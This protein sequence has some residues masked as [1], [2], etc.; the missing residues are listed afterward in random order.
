MPTNRI[1]ITRWTLAAL[2]S[3][4]AVGMSADQ[5]R[6]A[7][8]LQEEPRVVAQIDIPETLM[9]SDQGTG[10]DSFDAPVF[11]SGG[12]IQITTVGEPIVL[13]IGVRS[14]RHLLEYTDTATSITVTPVEGGM[15]LRVPIRDSDGN[16]TIR[17]IAVVPRFDGT[18]DSVSGIAQSIEIDLPTASIDLSSL[19]PRVGTASVKVLGTLSSFPGASRMTMTLGKGPGDEAAVAIESAAVRLGFA[20]EDIGF[21]VQFD[22]VGL[23][24]SIDT[25]TL[26]LQVG[27]AWVTSTGPDSVRVFRVAD[28]GSTGVVEAVMSDPVADPVLFT[29]TSPDGLSTFAIAAVRH[30]VA[31]PT[32]T[33]APTP[34][35]PPMPTPSPTPTLVPT[36]TAAAVPSPTA[37][38]TATPAVVP[39]LPTPTP[40]GGGG[41]NASAPGTAGGAGLAPLGDLLPMGLLIGGLYGWRRR[42][43]RPL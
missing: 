15:R 40:T 10:L 7:P 26:L 6:A 21:A 16:D 11:S 22:K 28:D 17:I 8:P 13:P 39:A 1:A 31:T 19:D 29:V 20:V 3:V 27:R 18:G 37:E 33:A 23:D 43:G 32:P 5:A 14:G 2:A 12:P 25:I 41:C 34:T 38:P 42:P 30:L 9:M 4:L 35:R 36:P 24:E